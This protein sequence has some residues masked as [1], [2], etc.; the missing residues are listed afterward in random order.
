MANSS[1]VGAA[2]AG[3]ALV[4]P[5]AGRTLLS[6]LWPGFVTLDAPFYLQTIHTVFQDHSLPL[7]RWVSRG[8]KVDPGAIRKTALM[9][10]E[11]EKDDISAPGQTRAAHDLC[12]GLRASQQETWLQ[13]GVGHYGVFNGSKWR[14]EIAPR[15]RAFIHKHNG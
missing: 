15:V 8:R 3:T 10:V 9:T 2:V 7:G 6:V 1:S 14:R 11:G 4:I 5:Y 13:P 12:T